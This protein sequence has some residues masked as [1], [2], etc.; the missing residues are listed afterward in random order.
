V[1]THESAALAAGYGFRPKIRLD[2]ESRCVDRGLQLRTGS[3]V[4]LEHVDEPFGDQTV[5]EAREVVVAALSRR[6]PAFS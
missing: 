4:R 6:D 3:Q 1:V 5:T 2:R